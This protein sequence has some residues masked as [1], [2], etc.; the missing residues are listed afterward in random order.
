MFK[1]TNCYQTKSNK[2]D[3]SDVLN[4]KLPQKNKITFYLNEF[5]TKIYDMI[6]EI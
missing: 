2:D 1:W 3:D 4:I 5:D 6:S